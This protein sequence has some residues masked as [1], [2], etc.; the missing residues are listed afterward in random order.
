[1]Q[2]NADITPSQLDLG[3]GFRCHICFCTPVHLNCIW[4]LS[5]SQLHDYLMSPLSF[6]AYSDAYITFL[7]ILLLQSCIEPTE[8]YNQIQLVQSICDCRDPKFNP[9]H[10]EKKLK[11]ELSFTIGISCKY[12]AWGINAWARF[13]NSRGIL[14]HPMPPSSPH[15]AL[16]ECLH[17]HHHHHLCHHLHRHTHHHWTLHECFQYFAFSPPNTKAHDI[18]SVSQSADFTKLPHIL[19][20]KSFLEDQ[21]Q[22]KN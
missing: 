6:G 3:V 8:L 18:Q 1:M 14:L 9:R 17:H 5:Q 13:A 16:H 19:H 12:I 10:R 7:V 11:R 4:M 15:L 22:K 20:L 2:S 21:F